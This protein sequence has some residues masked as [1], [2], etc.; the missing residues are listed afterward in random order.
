MRV[1][2]SSWIAEG[3]T[4]EKPRPLPQV[5]WTL[6]FWTLA[7]PALGNFCGQFLQIAAVR[8]F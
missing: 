2:S 1:G 4:L 6:A 5:P 8:G 3:Q 7:Q